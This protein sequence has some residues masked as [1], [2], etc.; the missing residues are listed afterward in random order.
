MVEDL[1]EAQAAGAREML[2]RSAALIV[3][4]DRQVSDT[5]T[6]WL[7]KLAS[8]LGLTAEEAH[9]LEAEV[10]GADQS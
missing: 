10:F 6:T 4:A 3:Q 8:E 5:E 7:G 2:Y 9:N 1:P